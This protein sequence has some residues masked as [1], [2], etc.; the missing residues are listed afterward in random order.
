MI[1]HMLTSVTIDQK[2]CNDGLRYLHIS[3]APQ[4]H[5][6]NDQRL[7]DALCL[8]NKSTS[9]KLRMND[10]LNLERHT[11]YTRIYIRRRIKDACE[12]GQWV[13]CQHTEALFAL[14]QKYRRLFQRVIFN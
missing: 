4:H 1:D 14:S 9:V 2:P 11:T 13:P 10:N 3:K 7:L 12:P 8:G 5:T 6:A